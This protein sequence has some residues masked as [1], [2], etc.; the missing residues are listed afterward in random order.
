[1]IIKTVAELIG[2]LQSLPDRTPVRMSP[3]TYNLR[4]ANVIV[5]SGLVIVIPS[6]TVEEETPQTAA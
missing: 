4:E 6:I 5:R 1:M 2:Y 3:D